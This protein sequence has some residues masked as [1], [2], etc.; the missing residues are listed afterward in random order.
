MATKEKQNAT[1][2]IFCDKK[3]RKY[4]VNTKGEYVQ[5]D[6]YVPIED[7][8]ILTWVGAARVCNKMLKHFGEVQGV[9]RCTFAHADKWHKEGD[10]YRFLDI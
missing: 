4:Y 2:V 6:K 7:L 5:F 1:F 8:R 10:Y 3:G 9:T